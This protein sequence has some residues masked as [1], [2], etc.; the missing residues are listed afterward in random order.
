MNT[1]TVI[2]PSIKHSWILVCWTANMRYRYFIIATEVHAERFRKELE[3]DQGDYATKQ[4]APLHLVLDPQVPWTEI[5]FEDRASKRA[6]EKMM[7]KQRKAGPI[8]S[9]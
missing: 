3:I 7:D 1:A 2:N 6:F 8:A 9:E 4:L 5:G